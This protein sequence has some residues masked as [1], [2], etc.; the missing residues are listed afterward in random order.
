[1]GHLGGMKKEA[2]IT[3][4]THPYD[5]PVISVFENKL[6]EGSPCWFC[7]LSDQHALRIAKDLLESVDRRVEL[8]LSDL[9]KT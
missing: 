8:G 4:T 5:R 1:M 9:N 3:I 2:L 7:N 6:D